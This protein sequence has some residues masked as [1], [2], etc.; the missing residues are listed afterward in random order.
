MDEL[1][2]TRTGITSI[3]NRPMQSD[4]NTHVIWSHHQH[5]QFCINLWAEILCNWLICPHILPARVSG[6]N[7]LQFLWTH[8]SGL[9]EDVSF[10]MH[11]HIWFQHDGGPL[12]FSCEVGQW[13]RKNCPACGIGHRCEAPLSWR[14]SSWFFSVGIHGN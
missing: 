9:L 4:E 11:L 14:E 6:R 10:S 13:P 12:H 5:W 2:F 8:L 1:C 7:S 3:Q